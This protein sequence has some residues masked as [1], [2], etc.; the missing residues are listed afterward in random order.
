M[1]D[2]IPLEMSL[3]I[4]LSSQYENVRLYRIECDYAEHFPERYEGGGDCLSLGYF[5]VQN[6][7][8]VIYLIQE[9]NMT[10]ELK[11]SEKIMLSGMVVCQEQEKRTF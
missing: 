1:S 7:S 11:K 8:G 2:K 10:D 5:Y 6:N 4:T 9:E 3:R